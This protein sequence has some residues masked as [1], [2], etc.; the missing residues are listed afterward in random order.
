MPSAKN[1]L[2]FG[3]TIIL[4][5]LFPKNTLAQEAN[6]EAIWGYSLSG[7]AHMPIIKD[8]IVYNAWTGGA[9]AATDLKTGELLRKADGVASATAP[10]IVGNRIY[11]YRGGKVTELDLNTFQKL[12]TITIPYAQYSENLPYDEDTGYFF[13]R[14][15]DY[16]SYYWGRTSAFR[17]SDGQIAWSFPNNFKDMWLGQQAPIV[18]GDSVYIFF[19]GAGKFSRVNKF[20]GQ[21]IWTADLGRGS[22]NG[23]NNPIYDPDNEYFYI[24]ESWNSID[25]E[26]N[27]VRKS[28]GNII[29]SISIPDRQIESTMTYYKNVLYLPLHVPSARGSYRAVDVLN[30]GK[31]IW[32]EQG[33]YNEDGWGVNAVSDK[34]LY[35]G[36]HGT[37]PPTPSYLIIQDRMT[38]ELIW[39]Y[40]VDRPVPCTNPVQSE[41][42]VI[43]GTASKLW[44]LKVGTGEK[45]DSGFHGLYAT[46]FNPGAINDGG[47]LVTLTPTNPPV[48]TP[49]DGN[50]DG[51]VDGQDFII[52]FTH[53]G[54]NISGADNGDYDGNRK[55]EIGDYVIWINNFGT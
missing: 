42:I 43:I 19:A 14:Q 35:R 26:V 20:N 54:Q 41:G 22:R 12:R 36:T 21:E 46:G 9:L 45:V 55:V 51:R 17:L 29:W 2:I 47:P 32:E 8:G 40:E 23:Y 24:S 11:S 27:A 34:Y 18:V 33:F 52:W 4:I 13:A 15:K 39:S 28:D 16:P 31:T 37:N 7:W 30:N 38:G 1:I 5:L 10:F 44:G 3:I 53:F 50:N 6:F 48:I 49:G 25:S